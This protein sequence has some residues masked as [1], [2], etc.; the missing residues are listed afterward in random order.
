MIKNKKQPQISQINA[1]FFALICVNLRF[2]LLTYCC[3]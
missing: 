2:D 3:F 1:D